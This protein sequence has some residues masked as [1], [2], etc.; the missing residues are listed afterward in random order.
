MRFAGQ[1]LLHG[2][3]VVYVVITLAFFLVR[4]TGDPVALL[5]GSEATAEQIA[6]IRRVLHLD[7]P[8][9][10][11]YVFYM[12]DVLHGDF[13]RSFFMPEPAMH[14]VLHTFPNSLVLAAAAVAAATAV[15]LPVGI[16]AAARPDRSADW[17]ARIMSVLGQCTPVFWLGI[18]SILLF[19][20]KLRWLP[21]GGIG[22]WQHLIL[23]ALTL[24]VVAVPIV[25]QVARSSL[26]EALRNDYIRT[27]RSKGL[28]E[29]RILL[30]H[31]LTNASLPILTVIGLRLGAVIGGA[32]VTETVFSY[33]GLGRLAVQAAVN[34]DFPVVQAFLV[35]TASAVVLINLATDWLYAV[36]DPRIRY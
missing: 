29:R 4:V 22:G 23:P 1:R 3:F 25:I 27:A 33:P 7:Q 34:R 14:L 20:V 11:Q 13:G 5:A 17:V 21:Y 28:A 31:A 6:Q 12:K 19:A 15:G 30:K 9:A 16:A 32:V 36:L 2:L 24:A 26:L 18:L 8:L 10:A 35:V